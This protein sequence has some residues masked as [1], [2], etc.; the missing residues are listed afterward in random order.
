M[1]TN[2]KMELDL[3]LGGVTWC[4]E[5]VRVNMMSNISSQV[6]ILPLDR[7]AGDGSWGPQAPH[8]NHLQSLQH[9]EG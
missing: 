6:G 5:G 7:D 8:Q 3:S 2:Q 9:R 4:G 1:E